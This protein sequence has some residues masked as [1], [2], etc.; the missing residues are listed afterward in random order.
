MTDIETIVR[1]IVRD[2]LA[3]AKPANDEPGHLTV[4]AYAARLSISERT[5]RDAIKDG[6][7]EH[8]RIG[9]AVRIPAIARIEPRTDLATKRARLAL[10][11]SG[12]R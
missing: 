3:K 7:L 8:V 9:R 12:K 1:Q 4:A 11:G 5:V 10:L 6:R 2:E